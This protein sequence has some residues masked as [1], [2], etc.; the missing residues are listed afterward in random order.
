MVEP[1]PEC[2]GA[3]EHASGQLLAE[4]LGGDLSSGLEAFRTARGIHQSQA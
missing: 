1:R 3:E 4:R 2:C